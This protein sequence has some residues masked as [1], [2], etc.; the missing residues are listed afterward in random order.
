MTN[1]RAVIGDNGP[2]LTPFEEISTEIAD[3]FQTA[4]DFCD[5]EPITSQAMHDDIEKLHDMLHESGKRAEEMR[6]AEKKP[7]DDAVKA[8][9]AKYNPLVQDKKGK[10]ALGKEACASLLAPWRNKIRLEKEEAARKERE[11]AVRIAQ[12]AQDAIRASAGNLAAREE[13]ESLLKEAKAVT[14][15][16]NRAD[17]A[18]VTGNRLRSIWLATLKAESDA[19][20]AALDYYYDRNPGAFRTLICDLAAAD[21]RSGARDIPGFVVT[22]TKVAA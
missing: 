21:V 2:P 7:L 4:K 10:V 9:Q 16:A 19:L 6:V 13:A 8:I 18:A 22:E 3:L 12:E 14:R 5:G 1:Q 20:P 15:Y 17:K 11:E